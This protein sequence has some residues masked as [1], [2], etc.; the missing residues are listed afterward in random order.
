MPI[1]AL[2]EPMLSVPLF[3]GLKPLQITEIAR[4]ADRIVYKSGDKI[5]ARGKQ[6]DAAILIISGEAEFADSAGEAQAGAPVPVGAL[7]AEIAMFIET[8]QTATIVAKGPV[9]ALRFSR[10]EILDQ[11]AADPELAHQLT[12]KISSRLTEFL[13]ELRT[14]DEEVSSIT[15]AAEDSGKV[16]T[17]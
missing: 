2:I 9:R 16:A 5:I 10:S 15:D 3:H 4:R 13:K 17:V 6:A 12:A 7:L 1:D 11:L 14:V 8:E